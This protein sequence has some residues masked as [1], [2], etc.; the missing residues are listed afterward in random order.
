MVPP[1]LL[2]C[3]SWPTACAC[4]TSCLLAWAGKTCC[5]MCRYKC[6]LPCSRAVLHSAR[7]RHRTVQ[8]ATRRAVSRPGEP[9]VK[10]GFSKQGSAGQPLQRAGLS[11]VCARLGASAFECRFVTHVLWCCAAGAGSA[12][13]PRQSGPMRGTFL[14]SPSGQRSRLELPGCWGGRMRSA[15]RQ[16]L[17][18]CCWD[19][20]TCCRPGR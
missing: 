8:L 17:H 15:G 18:A 11:F 1:R 2:R 19:F 4:P 5:T 9:S 20:E 10:L 16:C 6:V 12:S 3:G 7:R 14:H 13:H